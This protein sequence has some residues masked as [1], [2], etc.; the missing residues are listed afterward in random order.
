MNKPAPPSDMVASDLA[1]EPPGLLEL[2][3]AFSKMSLAGFGGVLVWARRAIVEQ[4]RWMTPDEFNEAFALCHLLPG[5]NIVN[6]SI[7]F[8]GRFRGAAG[9]LAA[10]LGLLLPPTLIVTTLGILYTHFGDLPGLQRTLNGIACAAV[11][12]FLAV[13]VRMIGPLLKRKN[14]V[15]IA[16][17]I[18]VFAAVGLGRVPL[19]AVVLIAL[20]LSIVVTYFWRRRAA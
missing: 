19:A 1:A 18:A 4:H 14:P 3:F 12:L 15:E 8:G 16:L 13:I 5:A 7:V 11:G 6:L 20:P 10:F 2:F 17:M 9:S